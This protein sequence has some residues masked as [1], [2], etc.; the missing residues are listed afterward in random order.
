MALILLPCV[1]RA[2]FDCLSASLAI[3]LEPSL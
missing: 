3:A 1:V 2:P